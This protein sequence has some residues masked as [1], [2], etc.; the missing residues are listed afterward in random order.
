MPS[1]RPGSGREAH[2]HGHGAGRQRPRF[3]LP[4]AGGHGQ[5]CRHTRQVPGGAPEA[6]RSR[7]LGACEI[8]LATGRLRAALRNDGATP[9][10]CR[11]T[12]LQVLGDGRNN[13]ILA[14]GV[15]MT[16]KEAGELAPQ[17]PLVSGSLM[18]SRSPQLIDRMTKLDPEPH[19]RLSPHQDS[20]FHT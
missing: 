15:E 13:S 16:A 4:G 11:I 1:R 2:G 19:V 20:F 7:A 5:G 10:G 17:P 3:H 8:L 14:R 6:G 12:G 18:S 9:F